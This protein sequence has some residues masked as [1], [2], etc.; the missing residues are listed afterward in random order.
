MVPQ[1]I[2]NYKLKSVAH[3]P[4]KTMTY[5]FLNTIVDDFFS[6]VIKMPFLHRLACFRD[7]VIF[8]ILIYQSFIYKVDYSR[9]NE[10]GQVGVQDEEVV[11]KELEEKEKEIEKEKK[12]GKKKVEKEKAE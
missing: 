10:Y 7:D 12:G 1:L 4:M 9:A 2:I 3:M 6:F 11:K 5:K 8:L